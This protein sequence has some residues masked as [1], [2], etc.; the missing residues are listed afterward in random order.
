M[1][2]I[3]QDYLTA[4]LRMTV[5]EAARDQPRRDRLYVCSEVSASGFI[6]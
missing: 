2:I 5:I 1:S 3:R 4:I 6:E